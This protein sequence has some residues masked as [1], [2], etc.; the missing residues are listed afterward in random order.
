MDQRSL[1]GVREH[2]TTPWSG[3]GD[4]PPPGPA[5]RRGGEQQGNYD[6]MF[7]R[8]MRDVD[9]PRCG[10]RPGDSALEHAVNMSQDCYFL[11]GRA[12]KYE[13]PADDP[14]RSRI[15]ISMSAYRL[16]LRRVT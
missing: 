4:A 9:I 6:L 8:F 15:I 12:S 5:D 13:F 14:Q 7:M 16:G 11:P 1:G 3:P 2:C 10:P